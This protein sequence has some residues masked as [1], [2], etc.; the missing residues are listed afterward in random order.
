MFCRRCEKTHMCA[1]PGCGHDKFENHK[2]DGSGA[3][4]SWRRHGALLVCQ[5]SGY[6]ESEKEKKCREGS[7]VEERWSE[8]VVDILRKVYESQHH[9]NPL[10]PEVSRLLNLG[11]R[12]AEQRKIV[13]QTHR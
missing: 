5:C 2:K 9:S 3:Y 13:I 4:C 1:R 8:N 11:V 10:R 12:L 6:I 7:G